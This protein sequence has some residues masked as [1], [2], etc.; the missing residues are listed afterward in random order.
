MKLQTFLLSRPAIVALA[1]V[2][3][4]AL[5]LV[6]VLKPK[7]SP[8]RRADTGADAGHVVTLPDVPPPEPRPAAPTPDPLA[9]LAPEAI[10]GR[11]A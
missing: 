7:A 3:L 10:S 6:M 9:A 5:V 4:L 8:P 1:V 2:A 11:P